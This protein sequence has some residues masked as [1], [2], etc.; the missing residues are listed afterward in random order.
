MKEKILEILKVTRNNG[1]SKK[2]VY[3][4]LAY[5][6]L[7]FEEFESVF[8]ELRENQEIYQ[9]GKDTYTLN[10]FQE[11]EIKITRKGSILAKTDKETYEITE[12]QFGCLTGDKV[13]IRITDFGT[14]KGTIKEVLDRKGTPAEVK[15][16]NNKKYA[17]VRNKE[18]ETKYELKTEENLVEGMI[19]GI[20]IEKHRK[21]KKT[22]A[23][24]DR[25]FGHKNRPGLDEK[26]ILYENNF[27]YEWPEALI[28]ELKYIPSEVSENIKKGRKDLRTKEIF[29]IDGDD[30]KDI[31]DAVSLEKL[32]NGNY[33]LGVHIADVTEYV[34]EGSELDKEAYKRATSVYMGNTVNPMYPVELSNGI[35]SL[36]PNTD[37]LALSVEMEINTKGKVI[38]YDIF[39]SV[40]NSKK[41]MTYNN[42][43]KILTNQ[44]TPVGY[45]NFVTTL[46]EMYE[47]SKILKKNRQNRGYQEFQTSEMKIET[48]E[49]DFP[50]GFHLRESGPGQKLIEMFMLSANETVAT[51]I[52]NLGIPSIYRDHDKP[53]EEKLKKV[54]QVIRDYGENFKTKGKLLS[55]KYISSM[56]EGLKESEKYETYNNMLLRCL[57]KATYEAYNIGHFSIGIDSERKEAYAHFTSPIRRYPDTL[58]HRILKMIIKKK[59]FNNQQNNINPNKQKIAS[60]ARHSS[61]Q[62]QNAD[63]CEREYQKMKTAEYMEEYIKNHQEETYEGIISGFAATGMYVA[64]PNLIEG[65]VGFD[66][67]DDFY[68][69]DE[70]REIIVGRDTGKIYRLGDKVTVKVTKASKI[71]REIDFEL[72]KQNQSKT[73]KRTIS[74]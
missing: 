49:K 25:I 20:K 32:E 64:L 31:D 50:I 68:N 15:I 65:R 22:V 73:R 58:L 51:Y 23:V 54:T 35:C 28:K 62:E 34:K 69:Y 66:T 4:K 10:P 52:Y 42:V 71:L 18:T 1:L 47:L 38:N 43:N 11:A 24:L 61:T 40:I 26:V 44:E 5:T 60:I 53:N 30:T 19:I 9:T 63:K 16:E 41:Q 39:E 17:I 57:A 46:K 74:W 27:N 48:N 33:L 6:N 29:T 8:E 3:K 37:R 14:K 2:E 67:M 72:A 21:D 36:N 70:E 7:S 45:E 56:L 59:V 12:D 55:P 13:K